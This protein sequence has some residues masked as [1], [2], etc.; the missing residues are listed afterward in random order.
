MI[1]AA[2]KKINLKN[3]EFKLRNVPTRLELRE[4]NEIKK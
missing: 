1:E 4:Q 2:K 3:P